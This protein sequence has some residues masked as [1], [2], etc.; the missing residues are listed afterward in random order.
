MPW[1]LAAEQSDLSAGAIHFYHGSSNHLAVI[2]EWKKQDDKI[3]AWCG[4]L[5]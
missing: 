5:K 3:S 4:E 1:K 2:E